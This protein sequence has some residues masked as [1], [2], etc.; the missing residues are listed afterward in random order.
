MKIL[1]YA[2]V[3]HHFQALLV[4]DAIDGGNNPCV[5]RFNLACASSAR[6]CSNLRGWRWSALAF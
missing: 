4:M 5:V 3:L 2:D 6:A 1:P